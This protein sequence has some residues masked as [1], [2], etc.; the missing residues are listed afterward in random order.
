MWL[1]NKWILLVLIVFLGFFLRFYKLDLVPSGLYVDEAVVGYNAYSFWKTGADE[2]GKKWPILLKSF[3]AYSSPIYTYVTT[4][5]VAV[6]GLGEFSVRFWSAVAGTIA[7]A[8]MYLIS[9]GSIWAAALTAVSPW[10][11]FLSRMGTEGHLAFVF[12]LIA[13]YSYLKSRKNNVWLILCFFLFALS[14][15]TYQAMRLVTPLTMFGLWFWLPIKDRWKN[16]WTW[17]AGL[18]FMI[19]NLPQLLLLTTNTFG[20]R[21][22][23]L[24]YGDTVRT[25]AEKIGWLPYQIAWLYSF[26]YE[27]LSQFVAYF[28][29]YT[30]FYL[31]DADLQRSVP[32]IS[33]FYQ[34][35]IVPYFLGIYLTIKNIKT[36]RSK[37]I[38]ITSLAAAIV[39]ALTKDPFS[40]VRSQG[41]ILPMVL[42]MTTALDYFDKKLERFKFVWALLVILS[43]LNWWRY[44]F[45]VFPAERAT[46]WSYGYKQLASEIKQRPDKHF[47]V[48]MGR[49][50]P[51]YIELLFYLEYPPQIYQGQFESVR[52][53]YY[54]VDGESL[55][56]SFANVETKNIE[57]R[58]DI[59]IDQIIVADS[60]AV[61]PDQEKEHKL[62]RVFEIKDLLGNIV[63]VGY[64]TNPVD[65]CQSDNYK[66][67][68]CG[69]LRKR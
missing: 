17:I 51:P 57:W 22:G 5:P 49:V 65:K 9:G 35:M 19:I 27:F 66:S 60:L 47:L 13:I 59:Y 39:P 61:S 29:P 32:E 34:W 63:F 16:K 23:G 37:L 53:N 64:E 62:K 11:I 36:D 4:I 7:I 50:K 20:L 14:M 24:F 3:D 43:L 30:L 48:D 21:A 15:N 8:M 56:R 52:Q 10:G 12:W 44:Y 38:I 42:L 54:K 58:R 68:R 41:L 67:E 45:W 26:V 25:G 69:Y 6:L 46:A 31:G 1:K 40:S 28:N 33:V 55:E 2:Y 18:I